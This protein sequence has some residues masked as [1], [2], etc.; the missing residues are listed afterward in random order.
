MNDLGWNHLLLHQI[1]RLN[2]NQISQPNCDSMIHRERRKC[3]R[4][5]A[6]VGVTSLQ[7]S[8]RSIKHQT[9]MRSGGEDPKLEK[10]ARRALPLLLANESLNHNQISLTGKSP[11][12]GK[13]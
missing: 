4:E 8:N 9:N 1:F 7:S 2:S 6:A 12:S 13:F 10:R 5:S 11:L 3:T